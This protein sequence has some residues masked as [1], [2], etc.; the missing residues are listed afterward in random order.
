MPADELTQR[1]FSAKSLL[2]SV[3]RLP[4]T[5][6]E[7]EAISPLIESVT[8]EKAILYKDRYAL[9]RVA[10]ALKHPSIVSFATHGF[11]LPSQA[12]RTSSVD[13]GSLDNGRSVDIQGRPIENPL[14]RCG[15]LLAG[16]NDRASVVGD[17][18]GILT[19]LEIVGIDLRGTDLVVLSACETGIGE[20]NN[21]EGVAGL[22]MRFSWPAPTRSWPRSGRCPIGPRRNWSQASSAG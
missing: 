5:A 13:S 14:L 20:I 8:G 22:R 17:D 18:D 4:N 9:E 11:F 21:G 2:P 1:S 15:L 6:A 7:A 19:G 16:C 12:A 3:G 10:K